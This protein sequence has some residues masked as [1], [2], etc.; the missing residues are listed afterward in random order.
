MNKPVEGVTCPEI[1]ETNLCPEV[2]A[3]ESVWTTSELVRLCP[4]KPTF[5]LR[6]EVFDLVS[7]SVYKVHSESWINQVCVH[8]Q[9]EDLPAE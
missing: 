9:A 7:R 3:L 8:V 4:F 1:L 6:A 2:Q 5:G